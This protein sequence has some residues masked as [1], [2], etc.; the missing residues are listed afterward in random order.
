MSL[1][2]QLA[3]NL[4]ALPAT[5]AVQTWLRQP[6][7]EAETT[8][9]EL[10]RFICERI[11][12]LP[13]PPTAQAW[14]EQAETL[15]DR[16]LKEV[17]LRGAPEAWLEHRTRIVWADTLT[18]HGSYRIRKL[19]YEALPG[20]WIPAL[21][22]EPTE[23]VGQVPAVLNVNGHVGPPGKAI[24]YEQIRCINLAKQGML[25]LHPEWLVFGELQGADYKH[26]RLAYLDL[27]GVS[28]LAVFYRA[29]QG[30]ID[31]LLEQPQTD[32]Q[33][34]AMTGLSGGGWQTIILSALD[35]RISLAVP[36]AGYI[37]LDQRVAHRSDIGDL[38]QNPTDLVS[39]ADYTHL[40]AMLAPR[41]ALLI[42]NE[43]DDCCFVAERAKASVFEPIKP[44]YELFERASPTEDNPDAFAYYMNTDPGTHNYDRDNREQF[45]RFIHQHFTGTQIEGEIPCDGELLN[46][47]ELAAGIPD[48]NANFYTLAHDL[49]AS[50]PKT[51]PTLSEEWKADARQ[52]LS[53]VLRLKQAIAVATAVESMASDDW[54]ATAYRIEVGSA[55]HV[56]VVVV[57]NA[58]PT[59]TVVVFG[60]V[61]RAKLSDRVQALLDAGAR[62]I[63]VDPLF[64]GEC[65]PQGTPPFQYAMMLS[66]VGERLLGIQVAQVGAVIQWAC[67][68]YG[69][70]RVEL[71]TD[72]WTSGTVALAVAALN[73]DCVER[74]QA[75]N[76]LDSLTHL[77]EA[78]LDY[79]QHPA[80]FCFGLL[81]QFDVP[82]LKA[83]SE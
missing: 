75:E 77:I 28:G 11:P 62:V 58:S 6:I 20:L 15:R 47:D 37:G 56:P 5:D 68:A 7:L 49:L 50:L 3:V 18:P 40:T 44:F 12:E 32:S 25:A 71:H 24:D 79:E 4:Y 64:M 13:A 60:D 41:P 65:V 21:L 61:G 31:V 1:W 66:T 53:D 51:P 34:V 78:H 63:A 29:M 48:G 52:R 69:V 54:Q 73:P 17:V 76:S 67:Q 22:Y 16:V 23:I 30:G 9:N 10:G 14:Q 46:P 42:Y 45:Y 70:Q 82:T 36:N 80:L 35:N 72:G 81:E 74:V 26:N 43:R 33:R 38:E 19:R 83:L 59:R 2:L 8:R 55:W 27:C 39:V 57:S